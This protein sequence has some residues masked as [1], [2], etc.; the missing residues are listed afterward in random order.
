MYGARIRN[1]GGARINRGKARIT[2][3]TF[4][5][6]SALVATRGARMR[7]NG[8]ARINRGNY[9]KAGIMGCHGPRNAKTDETKTQGT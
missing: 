8:G 5:M 4:H 2:K 1:K 3:V 9:C 6:P 7:N